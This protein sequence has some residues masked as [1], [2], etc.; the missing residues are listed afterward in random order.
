M[1]QELLIPHS[2]E[3]VVLKY[4]MNA[5]T[6]GLDGVVC[7]PL[8][9]KVLHDA[10]GSEFLTVT[11][12]IRFDDGEKGDQARITTPAKAKD[13][14]SDYIVVGRP[15]TRASNPVSVYERCVNEFVD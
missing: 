14:G 2:L 1:Q 7:S 3:S 6:A 8:E 11:P 10:L 5:K 13:L 15:I 4:A 12:G 9:S